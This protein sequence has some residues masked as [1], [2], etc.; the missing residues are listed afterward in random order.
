MR[1]LITGCKG[2]L[3][4]ELHKQLENGYSEIGS[5]PAQYKAPHVVGVDIDDFDLGDKQQVLNH[6]RGGSFDVVFNCAAFTNVDGCE[7]EPDAAYKTNALAARNLAMVCEQTATK[8]V[9]LSTDYVFPGDAAEPYREYDL[10]GPRTVYGKTKLAGENFVR[11]RCYRYFIVRTQW[12]YGYN[13]SNFVKTI[14]NAARQKGEISVVNDQFGCPTSAADLAHHLLKIAVDNR[15]GIYH[16]ANHGVASWYDFACEI[17]RLA[18]IDAKVNPCTTAEYPRPAQRPAYSAMDNMML[19]LG[20]GDEMRA[21]QDAL[22]EFV[23]NLE[24]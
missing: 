23:K 5:L 12:L 2:Q 22:A 24:Q 7:T 11:E 21:W 15:Y 16:C 18:G 6:V 3:G 13:G 20:V 4:R 19:R 10:S 9:H 1:I 8:L 14:M 17:V